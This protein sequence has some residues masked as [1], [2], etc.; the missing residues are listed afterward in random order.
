MIITKRAIP[1]R[2]VLQ[3]LGT[4]LALP[5]LDGMVPALTAV[6]RTPARPTN[7]LGVVYV[8]NGIVMD[9]WTPTTEGA[10]F[11]ITPILQPLAHFRD[12]L[13]VIS[14]LSNKGPDPIHETGATS[15]LTGMPP[16][17]TQGSQLRAGISM[18]Q[19]VAKV[20]GQHTQLASLELALESGDDVGTCGGGYTCA[21]TN[22]ISW[23]SPTTPLPME[24]NPRVVFERLLGDVGGTDPAARLARIEENRSL[25]DAVTDKVAQLR[26]DLGSH[27][28]NKL[29][30]YL[31]AVRDIE[32]R[33]EK[34]EAQ[35]DQQL[36][37]IAP[38]LGIPSLFDEH[39]K[40]M[41]DLQVLAYQTDLTRVISFMVSREYSG[42]TYPEIGVPEA[43]HPTSHHQNDQEKI[44]KLTKI[45]A[46]HTTLLS[47]FLDKLDATPDGSGSLLD[48]MTLLY[49][50]GLSDGNRHSSENL[51]IL[52]AGGGAGLL[53]GGR[54]VQCV[55]PTPMS[56]LHV[57]LMD[58]FGV[59][60]DS[61]G[62]S[63]EDLDILST[64]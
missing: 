47:Y 45:N 55:D 22:T 33:I 54:H 50:G 3:G 39:A 42:R 23:R 56:N 43:H 49:G 32:R 31:E 26:R 5:L 60:A 52:V 16:K 29:G 36:P 62:S 21:Y 14:G 64:L 7:R 18:D 13:L 48:N 27:D 11:E 57:T 59:P 20:F 28:R 15:F 10:G 53:K 58:K 61:F 51:P 40:L 17:R 24:T 25:L 9:Q 41:F 8:P 1:R 34:A 46:Y 35:V 30:E 63:T 2:T 12:R 4:T 44:A 38:P 37:E 19:Q 6:S